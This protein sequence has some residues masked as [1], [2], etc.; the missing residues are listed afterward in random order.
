[1]DREAPDGSGDVVVRVRQS[2]AC[3]SCQAQGAC[4]SLGGQ[5]R[6]L[7][8]RVPNALGAR[9][10]DQVAL[11]LPE[12]SVTQ[13]SLVLYLLPALTLV[14]GALLGA[15]V[16]GGSGANGA[17]LAGSALGLGVGLA[18][19]RLIGRRLGRRAAYR[20]RM[21]AI[22]TRAPQTPGQEPRSL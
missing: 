18:L 1:M 9:P 21:S 12:A 14:G 13:A 19:T 8:L 10:G 16:G 5:S 17:A 6:D 20:P 4:A 11:A 15:F 7:M 2:E 22:V 3:H